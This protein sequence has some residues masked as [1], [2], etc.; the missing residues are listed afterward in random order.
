[1]DKSGRVLFIVHDIYQEDNVFPSNVAYLAAALKKT[2]AEVTIYSQDVFHYSNKDLAKFLL[3][4][5][6]DLIGVGFMAARFKETI[7]DLCKVINDCKKDALLVLGG[8]GPS[9]IPEYMFSKTNADIVAIG[10]AEETIM[11]LLQCKLAGGNGLSKIKGI[12]YRQDGE[13]CVNERR[14]LIK[15]LDTI[16]FPEWDLFPIDKYAEGFKFYGH[17]DGD[18]YLGIVTSRG[19]VNRCN[20]CYRMD[21]GYRLRSIDNVVEEIKLLNKKYK[22]TFFSIY[23]DL[24]VFS[25]KHMLNFRDALK[26]NNIK[27][28][29]SGTARVDLIDEELIEILKECGCKFLNLGMESTSQNVLDLMNKRTKVEQNRKAAEIVKKS[30]IGMALNFLWGNKGDDEKSLKDNVEFI[31]KYNTYQQIRTIRP[32]TPYPGCDLYYDAIKRGLLSGPED[33]FE[34]FKN[35]D[36]LTVNFTNIPEKRFYELLFQANKELISDHFSHTSGDLNQAQDLIDQ[37]FNLYFKGGSKF[38]GAR[39]Y[40]KKN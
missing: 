15:N 24:F 7:I 25:K 29:F 17:E 30:G 12:A 26:K 19:C 22:I 37:F 35:S 3:Q 23:D 10:E 39:H 36:L 6:F 40:A 13:C 5:E 2:G 21:K 27:I 1:M 34:R 11:E 8:H 32:V 18:K 14:P 33:F 38:R 20:F 31:K 9:P 16:A 4:N 28:K